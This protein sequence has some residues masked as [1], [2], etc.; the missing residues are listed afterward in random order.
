MPPFAVCQL[1]ARHG[2]DINRK[3]NDVGRRSRVLF[4]NLPR[5]TGPHGDV[6]RGA[7][8]SAQCR[9]GALGAGRDGQHSVQV[10]RECVQRV[11]SV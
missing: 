8:G 10:R 1:L 6:V 11:C 2:A 7:A 4:S 3:A 9:Q 5:L